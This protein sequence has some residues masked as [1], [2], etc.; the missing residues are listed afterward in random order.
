MRTKH[1]YILQTP[2]EKALIK[3]K[4]QAIKKDYHKALAEACQLVIQEAMKL[5]ERFGDHSIQYYYV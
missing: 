3:A 4:R 1:K 5:H 2:I